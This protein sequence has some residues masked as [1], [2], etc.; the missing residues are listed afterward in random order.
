M[1]SV[2]HCEDQGKALWFRSEVLREITKGLFQSGAPQTRVPGKWDL[3]TGVEGQ[4]FVPGV[5]A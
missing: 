2:T 1:V 5:E 3:L 4:V